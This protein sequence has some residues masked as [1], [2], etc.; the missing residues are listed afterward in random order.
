MDMSQESDGLR[1]L[2]TQDLT[3]VLIRMALVA[4]MAYISLKIFSPFLGVMLWALVLAVT[5]YPL[6]QKLAAKLG[7]RQGRAA[8]ILVLAGMLLIDIPVV[9]M[10]SSVSDFARQ[11]QAS[12][13]ND[14]FSIKKPPESV[15]RVPIVGPRVY[16]AWQ[17][18]AEDL[19]K[20]IKKH[21]SSSQ[22]FTK[23][24]LGFASGFI[25]SIFQFFIAMVIAGIMMAWGKE[26][27]ESFLQISYRIAGYKAGASLHKLSTATIRSVSLGVIGVA[28]IQALL[29]GVGLYLIDFP[30]AGLLALFVLLLGIAQIPAVIVAIPAIIFI[31]YT[32]DSAAV[33]AVFTIYFVLAG[34]AD[35]VL[36]PFLL[37]RGV[38]APM[39][40]VLLGALGGAVSAG[41]IGLFIGAVFLSLTY[42]IFMSWVH[43]GLKKNDPS[44][45][46]QSPE[47]LAH[48][49]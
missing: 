36:K 26:A 35:N 33:N 16:S 46:N 15:A 42:V 31:W 17:Q 2:I 37:G 6:H 22:E 41:L 44:S 38:D 30:A 10:G 1:T 49:E 29:F 40:V 9:M 28:F 18:A 23:T 19:P 7:G 3:D 48:P 45:N 8:T 21:K 39:P 27:S 47:Q 20:F 14:T 24:A 43:D 5:L 25:S 32:G 12:F 34:L 11:T 4:L 13:K